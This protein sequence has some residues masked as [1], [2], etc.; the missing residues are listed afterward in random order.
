MLKGLRF[1]IFGQRSMGTKIILMMVLEDDLIKGVTL[2]DLFELQG[3]VEP[4]TIYTGINPKLT[5][6]PDS[7]IDRNDVK[8]GG[9]AG[10]MLREDWYCIREERP[11][12]LGIS[13]E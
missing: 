3:Y 4:K 2:P 13:I 9:I 5:I 6:F 8:G 11:D 10:I 7:L 1:K 12:Q